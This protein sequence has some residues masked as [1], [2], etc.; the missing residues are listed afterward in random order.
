MTNEEIKALG[1]DYEVCMCMDVTL[2]DI[3]TAIKNGHDTVEK[4]MD[5]TEAGTI[6]ELCQSREIDEDGERE[7]HLTEILEYAKTADL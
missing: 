5:E 6:C 1:D 3:L 4:I 2:G 7:L